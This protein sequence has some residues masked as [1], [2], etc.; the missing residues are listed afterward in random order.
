MIKSHVKDILTQIPKH[1]TIRFFHSQVGMRVEAQNS[2][3]DFETV[4]I[5]SYGE[6]LDTHRTEQAYIRRIEGKGFKV[7]VERGHA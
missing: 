6:T 5:E 1:V 3:G 4:S 7:T 2:K